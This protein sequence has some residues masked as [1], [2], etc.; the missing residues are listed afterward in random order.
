M[1]KDILTD[2]GYAELRVRLGDILAK[3]ES[4]MVLYTVEGWRS[5]VVEE[6]LQRARQADDGLPMGPIPEETVTI[7][8]SEL[9]TIAAELAVPVGKDDDSAKILDGVKSAVG[10]TVL[11]KPTEK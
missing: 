10:L 2:E 4:P 3:G 7:T 9:K 11:E 6:A 5:Y 8:K 1:R